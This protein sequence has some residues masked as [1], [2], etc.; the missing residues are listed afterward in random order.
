MSKN[1]K[2]DTALIIRGYREIRELQP[3]LITL[4]L[5]RGI[6]N[7][8][9]PFINIVISG[10][11]INFIVNGEPVK[12]LFILVGILIGANLSAHLLTSILNHVINSITSQFRY[13]YDA[14]IERKIQS[15]DYADIE[16]H[17]THDMRQLI[18]DYQTFGG[19]GLN[20]LVLRLQELIN[21]LFTIAFSIGL[22]FTAFTT[23][24]PSV[25]NA[26]SFIASPYFSII[27][28]LLIISNIVF[29]MKMSTR[30]TKESYTIGKSFLQINRLFHFYSDIIKNYKYGKE[31]RLYDQKAFILD[32]GF[33]AIKT[34]G[35][36]L[37]LK[38]TMMNVKYSVYREIFSIVTEMIIYVFVTIKALLG[39]FSVGEIVQYVGS[40]YQ[41]V[42]G[43]TS[44]ATVCADLRNSCEA[45]KLYFD[46]MD[47]PNKMHNGTCRVEKSG[48]YVIELKN[49]SFKYPEKEDYAI[50]N[51]DLKLKSGERIALVGMNGSGKT[52]MIKLLCRLYD[53]TDGEITLNGV[54]IKEYDYDEYVNIFSVV[55]QDFRLFSLELG[56]NVSASIEYDKARVENCLNEVGFSERLAEMPKGLNTCLYK[57]FE[58]D[59]VEISGGEAQ[60]IALARALYKDAPFVI[61]DEPTAALDPAAEYDIYSKFNKTIGNKAVIYISHR[62]S[63]CRFCNNIAVFHEGKLIQKGTHAELLA[64]RSGKYYELWNA[65]AKYYK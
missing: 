35:V 49:V 4:S 31:V 13:I 61:L 57:D 2:S 5:I 55:F 25:T 8:V 42:G 58:E 10:I 41:F 59:G 46:F 62:L 18:N 36:S 20:M 16:N 6:F 50:K 54:N 39:C 3:H 45:L 43:F 48:E 14:K 63:S 60:K 38:M 17:E 64:D 40:I 7:S 51:L 47:L 11:I 33:C 29:S 24:S 9:S 19:A 12:K 22:V 1:L 21:G 44:V 37:N 30:A 15:M 28:L 23:Y 32:K 53:P 26:V 34:D 52:T 65:Q 27:T 56:Q